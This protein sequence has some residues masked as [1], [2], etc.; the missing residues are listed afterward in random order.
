MSDRATTSARPSPLR[1]PR[2]ELRPRRRAALVRPG[3]ALAPGAGLA[4]PARRRHASSTSRRARASSPSGSSPPAIR[5][6]GLDQSPDM[7]AVARQPVRRPGRARRGVGDRAP[8]RGRVVRPP[9]VHL[10]AALRRRSGR[11]ARASSRG[12]SARAARSRSLEFCVPARH[13]AAA[14]GSL[15]RRRPAR[16]RAADLAAAGTTSAASSARRSAASTSA[17]RSSAS[18]SS[19]S[20]A[21]DHRRA[22]AAA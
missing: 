20:E 4:R 15:R 10:P 8:V 13:L 16:R 6:T 12:S 18:S 11:D 2:P 22:G 5:V 14:L 3:S 21:G 17:G 7:L 19:G 9:H 1:A